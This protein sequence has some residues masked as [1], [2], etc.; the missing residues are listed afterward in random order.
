MARIVTVQ[1][2]INQLLGVENKNVPITILI[3]NDGVDGQWISPHCFDFTIVDKTD[4]H[5]DDGEI[6]D[7]VILQCY[8]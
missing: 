2:L 8:R 6:E 5:P 4:C 7:V 1:D 3:T